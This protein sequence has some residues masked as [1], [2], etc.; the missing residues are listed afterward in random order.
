M[1]SFKFIKALIINCVLFLLPF[2]VW[3]KASAGDFAGE[4]LGP[5]LIVADFVGT[6]SLIVGGCSLFGALIRYRQHRVNPLAHPISTVVTL[7]LIGLILLI[8]PF[9]YLITGDAFSY[10]F[11]H[12]R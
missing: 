7:F 2:P 6:G 12:I 11:F 3:A 10:K 4:V 8:L 9:S 5:V 1:W